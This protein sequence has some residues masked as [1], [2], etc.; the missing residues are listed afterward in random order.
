MGP[1]LCTCMSAVSVA[2]GSSSDGALSLY[3]YECDEFWDEVPLC[4]PE[5]TNSPFEVNTPDE[6]KS[7]RK[8]QYR[9][10]TLLQR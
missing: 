9:K 10:L 2:M 1:S 5:T 6:Q 3:V 7:R 8:A 4:D